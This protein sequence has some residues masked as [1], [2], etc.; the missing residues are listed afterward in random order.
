MAK[1]IAALSN[2]QNV[3][4]GGEYF[5]DVKGE[6]SSWR[7]LRAYIELNGLKITAIWIKDD[8]FLNNGN[9]LIKIGERI[10]NLPSNKPKFGGSIPVDYEYGRKVAL[11]SRKIK[12]VGI[13]GSDLDTVEQYITI[14]AIYKD[15]K[16][17]LSVDELKEGVSWITITEI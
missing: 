11:N 15:F 4:E 13:E 2:G 14:S 12:L 17:T 9:E 1:W 16:V 7:K 3:T 5:E 6:P 10:Y 8:I